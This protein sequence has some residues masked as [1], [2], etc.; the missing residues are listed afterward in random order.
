[1]GGAKLMDASAV[2]HIAICTRDMEKSLAFYRDILG[3]K[4][5]FDGLS[6]I[7]PRGMLP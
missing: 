7:E 1:M 4:V 2:S 5:L 6:A 3:M